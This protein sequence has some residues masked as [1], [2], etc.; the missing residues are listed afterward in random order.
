MRSLPLVVLA[1][2]C[3]TPAKTTDT[4]GL[5][6]AVDADGDGFDTADDCDDGDASVNPEAEEACNGVDDDCDGDIDEGVALTFYV[7][8]DGDG[9][10]DPAALV[11]ACDLPDGA[12]LDGTDCDDTDPEIYPDAPERCDGVDQDCDGEIDEDIVSIWY[13]DAD[14][15]GYGDVDALLDECDPPEGYVADATDCDDA[16]AAAF[17]GN[18][19]VC[20]GLD[21]DC[22][23]TIDEGV[24]TTFYVDVD[25]D[26][27]GD[28]TQTIEDCDTPSGYADAAGDCDDAD[29]ETFPG[30][31]ERCDGADDDCDGTID[32]DDAV[33]AG[34][35]YADADSDGY[36]DAGASS[37]SCEAPS[38]S[39]SDATDCDDSDAAVNPAAT[40]I[41]NGI[42]DDCDADVD[43]AD[44]SLDSATASTWYADAD[45]DGYGDAAAT[46]LTC[47][48]PSG[49]VTDATDCDDADAAVNP[50]ATE[51][52]NGVDDDCDAVV[53]DADSSLDLSTAD[54]WYADAD[55]D[56]YGDAAATSTTCQQPSGTVAD[57]TDCDDTAAGV[58]PGA[59][60]V[61]NGIDDD[62]DADVDDAD[63]SLDLSTAGTWYAD[64][65]S[66]GYGDAA[67]SSTTCV[68]PSSTVTDDTDCDDADAT[69]YPGAIELRDGVDNDCDGTADDDLYPGSGEDGPLSV[70]GATDLSV[71][72]SGSRSV[73]DGVS[74]AVSALGSASITVDGTPAGIAA[75]DEV[76]LINLQGSPTAHA[77]VGTYEFASVTGVSGSDLSLAQAV[78][79]IY[80]E[81][82]NTDLSDQVII[83]QRVPQYTDVT[84]GAAGTL[85]AA[86]WDGLSGGLLVFRAS[87]TLAVAGGGALDMAAS[88]YPGGTTGTLGTNCD[89]YQGES[90]TGPGEGEYGGT[91]VAYNEATGEWAANGGGGGAHICGGGGEHAGGASAADSWTGGSATAAEA[92]GTYGETDLTTMFLGSGGGGVWNG[93]SA[94]TGTGPG[95][96]GGGGGLVYVGADAVDLAGGDA[97]L[98]YG[99]STTACAQGSWTYG[100]GGGAGGTV[101]II[102][103]D[104]VLAADSIDA[105]GG[106]GEARNIRVGGD[107]GDG[108]VRIDCTTCNGSAQ[109]SAAATTALDAASAPDAGYSAAP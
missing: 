90:Y 91:C 101:W 26:G 32:E 63:S 93:N 98:A 47:A 48:Q 19:E 28:G 79:E 22:N 60:E 27:Y 25:G 77:A 85:T 92:G 40:E 2:A 10:G 66:D 43:D 89:A 37:V 105:E 36:G 3:R 56:G 29:F 38:G 6:A 51:V 65:D 72:A 50:A 78:G 24:T 81:A 14:G 54:T 96:G 88:G 57:D 16:E 53:D 46:S 11:E 5:S 34:T 4:A 45:S 15:D 94:C 21:N 102:A 95:S 68:Q 9:F 8:A 80:G 41:C 39:V 107:G 75:G 49:T 20:D 74:Y 35:W 71:D 99:G 97:V 64:A 109:G 44:G 31:P 87:G 83:V 100:A 104:V 1:L 58:N 61:C 52:C 12:V 55:S 70:T 7:D 62:C 13:A 67:V 108:R 86:A 23:G 69:A 30:A 106:A 82:S 59:T 76:L 33:D 103:D 73:A 18:P 84:V 42:D 17:P